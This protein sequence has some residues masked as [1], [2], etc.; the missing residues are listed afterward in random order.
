MMKKMCVSCKVGNKF[1]YIIYKEFVLQ[2]ATYNN[3]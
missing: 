1:L 2:S 3:L